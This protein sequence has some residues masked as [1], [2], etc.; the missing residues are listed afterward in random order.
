MAR[1]VETRWTYEML[2][3]FPENDGKRYEILDGELV[4]N[5]SP[6]RRHQQ[7]S[8]RLQYHLYRHVEV[9]GKRGEV[10]NAPFDVILSQDNVVVPDLIYVSLE[11]AAGFSKRGLECAPDLVVEILSPSTRGHDRGAV[12]RMRAFGATRRIYARFGV[13]ELW[14]VDPD[15]DTVEVWRLEAGEYVLGGRHGAGDRLVSSVLSELD[16]PLADVFSA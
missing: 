4:V 15:D 2:Q 11:R 13:L 10:Y 5:A 14:L 6:S 7:L 16:L 9:E 12:C 3:Q 1:P 8:K